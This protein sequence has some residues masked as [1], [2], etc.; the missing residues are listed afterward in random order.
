MKTLDQKKAMI[1]RLVSLGVSLGKAT[2]LVNQA[3]K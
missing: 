2:K 1:K 3:Y